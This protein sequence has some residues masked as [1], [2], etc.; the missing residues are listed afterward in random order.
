MPYC[1]VCGAEEL[2]DQ[3][4]CTSCGTPSATGPFAT[5]APLPYFEP[6]AANAADAAGIAGFWW[7]V[8]SFVIDVILVTIV[9]VIVGLAFGSSGKHLVVAAIIGTIVSFL[10]FGL[11]LRY[12]RG[13]TLGMAATNLRCV[14][15]SDRGPLRASQVYLRT[16]AYCVLLFVNNLYHLTTYKHPTVA[17]SAHQRHEL[18]IAFVFVLPHALDLLWAAWDRNRQTLHDKVASTIVLREPR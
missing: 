11:L 4:F 15:L 8:L 10:Y 12:R 2:A 9:S 7:R 6:E 13:Q 1:K 16:G 18:L 17:Q 14:N 3:K 5:P